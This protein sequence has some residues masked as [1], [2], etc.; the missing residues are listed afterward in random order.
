VIN[1]IYIVDDFY[2]NP[3]EVAA[4]A[5]SQEWTQK[6]GGEHFKRTVGFPLLNLIPELERITGETCIPDEY[7]WTSL[8]DPENFNASFYKLVR[9][10]RVPNWIHHDWTS[11]TGM[12]YLD[13]DVP[14]SWGTSLW[15]H[16]RTGQEATL[17]RSNKDNGPGTYDPYT[18][19][20]KENWE[21]TDS[22]AY[23]YNRLVL[24]RGF[25]YHT[26]DVPDDVN[27]EYE[28]LNQ[29]LYF[30]TVEGV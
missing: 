8:N 25:M 12:I 10:Y 15:R 1:N 11:W 24:F 4:F 28:R 18:D 14:P 2:H 13:K 20:P 21:Q 27:M 22:F 6:A 26:V 5:Q 7:N 9:G 23:K 30:N 17:W 3:D 19:E 29:L 16:K